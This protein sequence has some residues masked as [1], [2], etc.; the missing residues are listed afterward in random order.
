MSGESP[1][2]GE[3]NEMTMP[4]RHMILSPGGLNPNT[5]P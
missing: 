1:E 5:L 3:M 4:S 2:D